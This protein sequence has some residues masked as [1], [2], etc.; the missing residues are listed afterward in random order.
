MYP[1]VFSLSRISRPVSGQ[2]AAWLA[3]IRL[4]TECNL[5]HR[6]DHED[7]RDR[8]R[9]PSMPC[10]HARTHTCTHA[11]THT[12]MHASMHGSAWMGN[13]LSGLVRHY[14][15][16]LRDPWNVLDCSCVVISAISLQTEGIK[17]LKTL[18]A[19]R[20][21]WPLRLISRNQ[22]LQLAVNCIIGSL[23]G[24]CEMGLL[25][26]VRSLPPN[27][28]Q[29]IVGGQCRRFQEEWIDCISSKA[30]WI[31]EVKLVMG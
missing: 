27:C 14:G 12:C 20:A 8:P 21:I 15:A 30:G 31:F 28:R 6:D 1:V 3:C 16:Y 29:A 18:R 4:G 2:R 22:G 25:M 24:C 11:R 23:R 17:P 13:R 19:F 26:S 5:L 10:T 9:H 7:C